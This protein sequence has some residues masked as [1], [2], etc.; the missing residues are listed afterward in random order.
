MN[1][2][3]K[4]DYNLRLKGYRDAELVLMWSLSFVIL[5]ILSL[6]CGM[7]LRYGMNFWLVVS[8]AEPVFP[9]WVGFVLSMLVSKAGNI[10]LVF[11]FITW[12]ASFFF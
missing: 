9:L 12:L 8:G 10:F 5:S 3:K 11:A 2:L 6:L 1:K 4:I 7:A